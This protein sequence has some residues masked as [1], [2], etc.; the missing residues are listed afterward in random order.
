[1]NETHQ[2]PDTG[3]ATQPPTRATRGRRLTLADARDVAALCAKRASERE[4]CA[5][6]GIPYSTWA[7]YK[8][9]HRN[10]EAFAQ[11][12]DA[13]KGAKIESHMA[14]IEAASKKDWRA[15]ECYLEKTIPD[16]FSSKAA[17]VEINTGNQSTIMIAAGG[18][19]AVMK[20]L[21]TIYAEQ[22]KQG[23]VAPSAALKQI[24]AAV[25]V[26]PGA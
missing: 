3:Q 12:V 17:A 11:I 18:E 5:H 20:M 2:T 26:E 6:L 21:D 24:A 7:H 16:R 25:E 8:S 14:N 23:Q 19:G 1:M 4:A 10:A 15:S 9:K 22:A 13:I